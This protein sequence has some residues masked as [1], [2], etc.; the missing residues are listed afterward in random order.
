[1]LPSVASAA[2]AQEAASRRSG[3]ARWVYPSSLSTPVIRMVRSVSME[4]IA[5]IFCS[6]QMRSSISGSTAALDS[7]VTP[8]ARTAVSSTCSVEPTDGY[9]SRI[10][11]PR[12][13]CGASRYWPSARFSMVAPNWRS[14]SKWKSIGRPPM[15]QPPRPGMKAWPRRCS[16]G[17]QNRIGM[18]DDP[19]WASMSATFADSTCEGSRISSPGSSPGRT[20]TPW[21]WR[22]PRTTRTSR[23]SG[24]LRRRLGPLPSSAATMAFGTRFLAPRTRISPSSGVPPWTSRTSSVPVMYL[25]FRSGRAGGQRKG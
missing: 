22:S 20:V 8:S 15:S 6:T 19:A 14:T 12:S 25:A 11:V 23:M 18:R 3:I 1:M 17:P 10:L 7:S 24:T 2:D 5:P 9:G 21:S 4:M 13:R 16:S